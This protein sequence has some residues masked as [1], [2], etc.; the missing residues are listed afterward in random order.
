[1]EALRQWKELNL[2]QLLR[3]TQA[4]HAFRTLYFRR[5]KVHEGRKVT[6]QWKARFSSTRKKSKEVFRTF[7]L[8]K[9]FAHSFVSAVDF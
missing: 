2:I 6:R 1:M 9:L 8:L 7:L 3:Q 4:L 5:V